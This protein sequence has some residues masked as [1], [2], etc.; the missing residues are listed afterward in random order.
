MYKFMKRN[1]RK[2]LAIFAAGLM[3]V[4]ILPT[5][6]KGSQGNGARN[7]RTVGRVAA[8]DADFKASDLAMAKEDIEILSRLPLRG[9]SL[10]AIFILASMQ[11]VQRYYMMMSFGQAG[12]PPAPIQE[13]M[14]HPEL[15]A[16]LEKE[17]RLMGVSV[18]P[19]RLG[20]VLANEIVIPE[21]LDAETKD[22]YRLAVANLLTVQ[23]AFDR[24]ASN[25]HI[26]EP[27]KRRS[28]AQFDQKLTLDI[29]EFPTKDYLANVAAPTTQQVANQFEKYAND[30]ADGGDPKVNPFGFGYR[31]PN[32]VKLQYITVNRDAVRESIKP[33]KLT[34]DEQYNWEVSANKYYAANKA[35]FT[36]TQPSTKPSGVPFA[37]DAT[38]QPTSGPSIKP[39]TE[40]KE[41]VISRLVRDAT[42]KKIEAIQNKISSKLASD[43]LTYSQIATTSTT[44][45]SAAM[46]S[47][48]VPYNSYEYLQALAADIQKQ[49][50]VLPQV[51]SVADDF[52]T[53]DQLT[54]L[55][56]IGRSH[57]NNQPFG[58]YAIGAAEAFAP[59][60]MKTSSNALHL[61]QPSRPV[62]DDLE[63]VYVFRLMA[64]DPSH[65]PLSAT[66]VAGKVEMDWKQATAYDQ[67]RTAANQLIAT[68]K[69][70]G[71]L[72][73]TAEAAKKA[74]ITAGPFDG[75]RARD[76]PGFSVSDNISRM[77]FLKGAVDL[78]GFATPE[79]PRPIRVIELPR[80][81]KVLI[82]QLAKVEPAWKP[83]AQYADEMQIS[84]Q[85]RQEFE[86]QLRVEWFDYDNVVARL[87]YTANETEEGSSE[88]PLPKN[89]TGP[90]EPMPRL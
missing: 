80:E 90:Q 59:P 54:A 25:I 42:D 84:E 88:K 69:T 4:F 11:D 61:Y 41:E 63:N 49:D 8:Y 18:S 3:V 53:V 85:I 20:T 15:L 33:T 13:L 79:N 32:R 56:G 57:F 26:S 65:T 1:Q 73:S 6:F 76:I 66:E 52:K 50:G 89:P 24:T 12:A 10:P 46:T 22:R 64:T 21:T 82:A 9:T 48:G 23:A 35:L 86:R 74:V 14:T 38:S 39:F 17:A 36:T 72:K 70:S 55:P 77:L 43:W 47:F 37:L 7:D 29:V 34:E 58:V 31:Y 45:A 67:A 62:R 27:M 83:D 16:M 30:S 28:L 19:D 51:T 60:A 2:M 75:L 40:V 68:A 87:R 71:N 78:L 81:G 5:T 44:K